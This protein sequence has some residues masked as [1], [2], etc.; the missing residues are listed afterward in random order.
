MW[1]SSASGSR[2]RDKKAVKRAANF[3]SASSRLFGVASDAILRR[4]MPKGAECQWKA[5]EKEGKAAERSRRTIK[6]RRGEIVKQ[7]RAQGD[8]LMYF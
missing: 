6:A 4:F 3:L 8:G 1:A 7:T 2:L 5:D